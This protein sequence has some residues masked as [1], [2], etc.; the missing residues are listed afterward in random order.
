MRNLDVD[1]LFTNILLEETIDISLI[2]FWKYGKSSRFV[3]NRIQENLSLGTKESYFI[4]NGTF[5]KQFDEVAMG[6]N[7]GSMLANASLVQFGK[8]WLQV[9]PYDFKIYYY[10]V[11]INDIL[12]FIFYLLHQNI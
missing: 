5:C 2:H 4:F 6:L 9:C 10:R 3:K 1:S 8:N 12:Y 7:S 11:Y